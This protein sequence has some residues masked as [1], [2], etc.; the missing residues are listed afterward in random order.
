MKGLLSFVAFLLHFFVDSTFGGTIVCDDYLECAFTVIE[1]EEGEDC[2]VECSNTAACRASIVDCPDGYDCSV[3]CSGNNA[4]N[5]F[6]LNCGENSEGNDATCELDCSARSACKLGTITSTASV[7]NVT[8]SGAIS[9]CEEVVLNC[10]ESDTCEMNCDG[11]ANAC[12]GAQL[13][14]PV[15]GMLFVFLFEIA[16]KL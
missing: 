4:C 11:E 12:A 7:T 9:V 3:T 13:L 6:N 2:I 8:C 14:C 15:G 16:Q 1:C 10:E 5:D